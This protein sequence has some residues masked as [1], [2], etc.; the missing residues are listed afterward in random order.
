[1]TGWLIAP[2]SDLLPTDWQGITTLSMIIHKCEIK[3]F[4]DYPNMCMKK[5]P[6]HAMPPLW[7]TGQPDASKVKWLTSLL[8]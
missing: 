8:V 2:K 6:Y 1:M 7:P 5:Y 4:W 3:K